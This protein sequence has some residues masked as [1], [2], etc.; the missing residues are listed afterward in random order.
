MSRR[1]ADG[2]ELEALTPWLIADPLLLDALD[3]YRAAVRDWSS[4]T[5]VCTTRTPWS[6]SSKA[7]RRGP[8]RSAPTF[9]LSGGAC[10]VPRCRSG[11]K[12]GW[13]GAGRQSLSSRG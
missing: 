13:S 6:G 4:T 11:P 9:P 3:L 10:E 12:Q 5:M 1:C 7:D 8:G 2:G